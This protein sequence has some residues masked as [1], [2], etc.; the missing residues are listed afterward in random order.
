MADL[1]G[2]LLGVN[3]T[4]TSNGGIA[5]LGLGGSLLGGNSSDPL[6]TLNAGS[7][8]LDAN[9]LLN[10]VGGTV[11]SLLDTGTGAVNGLIGDATTTVSSLSSGLGGSIGGLGDVVGTV[12]GTATTVGDILSGLVGDAG[13]VIDTVLGTGPGPGPNPPPSDP[14]TSTGSAGVQIFHTVN[15][16]VLIGTNN[17]DT[18]TGASGNDHFY[19][20]GGNDKVDGSF[21]Y[22]T[23]FLQGTRSQYG[24]NLSNGVLTLTDT[25]S[26]RDGA[27]QISNVERIAFTDSTVAFDINGDAGQAYRLYQAAFNRTPDQHGLSYWVSQLDHGASLLQVA[28]AF[29]VSDEFRQT[30]GSNLSNQ[31]FV[32]AMYTN[33]LGRNADTSGSSYW[34]SQLNAG[35]SR[36]QVLLGFSESPENH[37]HVDPS[38]ATGILLD[39]GTYI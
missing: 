29:V 6:L 26:G 12:N 35:Q 4:N 33:I 8:L 2:G 7:N 27:D 34:V 23:V 11:N 36:A 18:M 20:L 22:D 3:T 14:G 39:Y 16:D 13:N 37:S 38:L 24:A 28:Q 15:G 1:L 30:F 17:N 31:A 21:G 10:T 5:N 25:V 9:G 19:P 32:N